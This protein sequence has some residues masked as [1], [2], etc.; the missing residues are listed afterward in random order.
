MA[1]DILKE[2]IENGLGNDASFLTS[3]HL[4]EVQIEMLDGLEKILQQKKHKISLKMF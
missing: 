4:L 3:Y 1:K 2:G